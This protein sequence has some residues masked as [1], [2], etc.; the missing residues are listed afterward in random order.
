MLCVGAG[1]K[2]YTYYGRS[3]PK[4]GNHTPFKS[5]RYTPVLY[6]KYCVAGPQTQ[7]RKK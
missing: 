6:D 2:E 1:M 4:L 7:L 3:Q 5:H